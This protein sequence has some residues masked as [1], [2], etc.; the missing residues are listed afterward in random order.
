MNDTS[1]TTTAPAPPSSAFLPPQAPILSLD[2]L[3]DICRSFRDR[4]RRVVHCHGAFDLLHPGHLMHFRAARAMGD[5][6]VVTLTADRFIRKGSNRPVFP[7]RLR[8]EALAAL[9]VV[10]YVAVVPFPTGVEAIVAVRPHVYVK[11]QDYAD[12]TRDVHGVIAAEEAAV[13]RFGGRLA[14]THEV[15]FSSTRLLREHFGM[16]AAE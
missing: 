5:M 16:R 4:G 13:Q 14:F 10:D 9:R 11:G 3:S 6:L 1:A 2:D 15:Q 7:E 8:A 12:R